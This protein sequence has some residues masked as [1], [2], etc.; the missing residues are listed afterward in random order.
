MV[1]APRL[2]S[3]GFT[4]DPVA[5]QV[6][7]VHIQV[8]IKN[9]VV[10][11]EAPSRR[12]DEAIGRHAFDPQIKFRNPRD[13]P[14]IQ[15][16]VERRSSRGRKRR[17]LVMRQHIDINI[18]PFPDLPGEVKACEARAGIIARKLDVG[19]YGAK[20]G[21]TVPEGPESKRDM[22]LAGKNVGAGEADLN[23]LKRMVS[24]PPDGIT[25]ERLKA[26]L[27]SVNEGCLWKLGVSGQLAEEIIQTK[28]TEYLRDSWN[29]KR[30]RLVDSQHPKRLCVVAHQHRT[31]LARPPIQA[32][33]AD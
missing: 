5:E 8:A 1:S 13:T 28:R 31:A 30:L 18:D 33:F 26:Q 3:V 10:E 17:N 9:F 25:C 7:V 15:A 27:L 16:G 23:A 4:P 29:I 11:E 32:L 2:I 19:R 24:I 14:Q 20:A 6:A 22:I 21:K 12:R